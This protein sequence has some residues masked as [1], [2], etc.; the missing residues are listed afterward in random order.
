MK[1]T[2]CDKCRTMLNYSTLYNKVAILYLVGKEL[3]DSLALSADFVFRPESAS[4]DSKQSN[5][6]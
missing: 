5:F 4:F 2:K 3:S 6:T 1:N